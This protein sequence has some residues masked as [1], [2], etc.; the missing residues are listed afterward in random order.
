MLKR[1]FMFLYLNFIGAVKIAKEQI[2]DRQRSLNEKGERHFADVFTVT[3]EQIWARYL[4]GD[5]IST[6]I[7]SSRVEIEI[8]EASSTFWKIEIK[9]GE[10]SPIDLAHTRNDWRTSLN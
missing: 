4:E 10:A 2:Y 5:N 8:G 1:I 9:I 7:E 6:K 3:W